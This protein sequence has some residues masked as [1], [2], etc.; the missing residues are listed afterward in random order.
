MLEIT[1]NTFGDAFGDLFGEFYG[2]DNEGKKE[3]LNSLGVRYI[4]RFHH[5]TLQE[6]K[7]LKLENKINKAKEKGIKCIDLD[8]LLKIE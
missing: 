3:Y 7:E 5:M 1:Y 6:I 8:N 4:T 2:I